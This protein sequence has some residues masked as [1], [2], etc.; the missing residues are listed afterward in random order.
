MPF[1]MNLW[2]IDHNE[3]KEVPKSRLDSEE[4]LEN[5]IA[6]DSNITGLDIL[7]IGRQVV[8]FYGGRI[9]LLG[10]DSEGN[11]VILELKKDKTPRDVVAQ[12]LDYA[13][14]IKDLTYKQIEAITMNYL[15]CSL[16][17]AFADKFLTDIPEEIN[18]NHSIVII[19]S[20]LDSSSERIVHY[21]SSEYDMNINCIFFDFF[22]EGNQE[23][24]GRSWLMDPEDIADRTESKKSA[25]WSG[26]YFVNVG[27]GKHRSWEDCKE[28]SF[29]SAGQGSK[30]SGPMK[31]LKVGDKVLAYL[32]GKGYVGFGE[33]TSAAVLAKDFKLSNNTLLFDNELKQPNIQEN[34]DDPELAD[35][36]VGVRWFKTFERENAL[37]KPGIFANQNI[38]CKLRHQPT[39]DFLSSHYAIKQD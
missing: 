38:V 33:I 22:K 14:W 25:P 21:L 7:L 12:T 15:K 29:L 32:K 2:K 35:W 37:T 4:R 11:L 34:K 24:L 27:D 6:H 30:Y 19:A 5:W 36:T 20:E 1:N 26:L 13:S 16:K 10:M 18:K 28:Y 3:L 17:D 23:F 8:T 31:K 39:I 9:D